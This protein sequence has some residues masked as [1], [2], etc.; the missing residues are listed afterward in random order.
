MV[1]GKVIDSGDLVM[2]DVDNSHWT[3]ALASSR[4]M[5]QH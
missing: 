5:T 4:M 2:L 3:Y 1:I